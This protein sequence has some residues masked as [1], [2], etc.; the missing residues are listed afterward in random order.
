MDDQNIRRF[1]RATRVQTFGRDRAADFASGGKAAALFAELDPIIAKLTAARVGQLRGPVGK[2]A[3]IEALSEDFKDI[4]RT[5]RAIALDDP[6]FNPAPYRHPASYVETAVAT[7]ADALLGLLEDKDTDTPVEIAAKAALRA[8]FTAY[9]L[10]ADFVEDL[11]A[12]RDAL[13]ACNAAKHSDNQEG[14]ES[15]A[16]IDDLLLQVNAIVTR[17]EAAVQNRYKN[18]PEKIAAWKSASRIERTAR[19]KKDAGDEPAPPAV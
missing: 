15:T 14:V 5:A 9:E 19:K 12:D 8:K 4:A 17:L 2:D 3:L 7:H 11:R 10:P 6:A 16:A 13:T 18:D 1:S